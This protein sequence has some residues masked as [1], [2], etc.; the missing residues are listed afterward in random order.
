MELT[1]ATIQSYR[2]REG[3]QPC[4]SLY[5]PTHPQST[6]QRINEDKIRFKNALQ[7][8]EDQGVFSDSLAPVY[9]Q[10]M[11]L[12]DDNDFWLHQNFSLAIM[13]NPSGFD[14]LGLPYE[15]TPVS[16]VGDH[17]ALS[18]L[19][20]MQNMGQT[21]YII[22]TDL[23]QPK[24]HYGSCLGLQEVD[25]VDLPS[26]I[27][28]QASAEDDAEATDSQDYNVGRY[29]RRLAES[30]DGF[31]TGKTDPLLVIGSP[32]LTSQFRAL[33]NYDNVLPDDLAASR[34]Q[35]QP[36]ELQASASQIV[37]EIASRRRQE[38]IQ[39]Y[40]DTD[41]E[42]RVD[43]QRPVAAAAAEGRVERLYLPVIRTTT[44]S[45]RSD[46]QLS[47][48]IELPDDLAGFEAALR[49]VADQSGDIVPVE[50]DAFGGG[51]G[52]RAIL[53]F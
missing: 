10:L 27:D 36:Q 45:V 7:E 38:S 29:L 47:P 39:R 49:Q 44:D 6:S 19:L 43:G 51:G 24:L 30:V 5:I 23:Q 3:K 48:L 33:L 18:P 46:S 37:T 40:H 53:R 26:G 9:G 1:D 28:N 22:D 16:Y 52:M 25:Q 11:G 15:L 41:P 50:Q 2:Q 8:L 20:I 42:L 35:H 34:E 21:Y 17:Y 14:S 32:E 31:L 4:V 12:M 13:A